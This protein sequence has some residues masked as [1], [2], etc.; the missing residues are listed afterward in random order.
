MIAGQSKRT[1]LSGVRHMVQL[2]T[3]LEKS[4]SAYTCAAVAAGVSLLAMTKSAEAKIVYTPA[5]VSIPI[6]GSPVLLDL[7]HDG[8]ADFA[9]RNTAN[10]TSSSGGRLYAALNINRRNQENEVWGKGVSDRRFASALHAGIPVRSNK[11]YFQQGPEGK[12]AKFLVLYSY[13]GY[14]SQSDTSGQWLYTK[15]RYLGLKFIVSGEVHYGWARVAVTLDRTKGIAATL[16]GYAYETIP[17]KPIITGKTKGSDVV[18]LEPA[19]LGHLAQGASGISGWR[20]KK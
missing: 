9:F 13:M 8:I 7:N 20:E 3:E 4:L 14:L 1:H 15:H 5:N 19:T 2:G 10:P 17:N 12:L 16:T 11:S 6:N 18:T